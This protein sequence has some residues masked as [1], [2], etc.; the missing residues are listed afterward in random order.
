[1]SYAI[2]AP[3][4]PKPSIPVQVG[5]GSPAYNLFELR[6]S[7]HSFSLHQSSFHGIFGGK[8]GE[9]AFETLPSPLINLVFIIQQKLQNFNLNNSP[10]S[11]KALGGLMSKRFTDI[12]KWKNQWFRSLPTKAKLAWI[13]LCDE[14]DFTGIWTVDYETA[15]LHLGFIISEPLLSDWLGDKVFFLTTE[16]M[17]IIKF[18][19]FQYGE[20]K[21]NW[22][23]KVRA[24]KKLEAMGFTFE[25]GKLLK[26]ANHSP[27]TVAPQSPDCTNK[28]YNYNSNFNLEGGVGETDLEAVY[29]LYP[30]KKGKEK[31]FEKLKAQIKTKQDL[32]DIT[33][34]ILRYKEELAKEGTL[35]RFMLHFST[36]MTSWRDC[37]DPEYGTAEKLEKPKRDFSFLREAK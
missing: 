24:Q 12:A 8:L 37:L 13:Y 11:R 6:H 29:K 22:S 15:S 21:D 14:C 4:F 31:G 18:F 30:R 9:T 1:M 10:D 23:P 33:K 26:P 2:L 7:L 5:V 3:L 36:F 35:P 20:S 16:K 27:P 25:N 17:L 34:A 28:S 32:E 19:E